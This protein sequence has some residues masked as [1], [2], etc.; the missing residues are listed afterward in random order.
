MFQLCKK[1]MYVKKQIIH[2]NIHV[3][4][5]IFE[6]KESVF[7]Q[8]T[9]VNEKIILQGLDSATYEQQNKLQLEWIELTKHKEIY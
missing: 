4:K 3:F 7:Q 8:L 2:W 5:N 6:Q 9:Q 1:L